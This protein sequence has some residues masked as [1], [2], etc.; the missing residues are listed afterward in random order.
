MGEGGGGSDKR[1]TKVASFL[2][3]APQPL[4]GCL[5]KIELGSGKGEMSVPEKRHVVLG[6][7]VVGS[8]WG[9]CEV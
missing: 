8:Q 6:V 7:E 3:E 4:E 5:C 9:V 1:S 2:D